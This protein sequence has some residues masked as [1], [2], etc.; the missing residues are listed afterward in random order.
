ML[1]DPFAGGAPDSWCVS[2]ENAGSGADGFSFSLLCLVHPSLS[3]SVL[4]PGFEAYREVFSY[5]RHVVS[6]SKSDP[7]FVHRAG[8]PLFLPRSLADDKLVDFPFCF[9]SRGHNHSPSGSAHALLPGIKF[10]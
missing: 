8:S 6:A 9:R 10:V 7:R 4:T 3:A 1:T 2:D 5:W